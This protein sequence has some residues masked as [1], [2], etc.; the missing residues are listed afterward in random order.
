MS[1][2]P[3]GKKSVVNTI[4][5][6]RT[7]RLGWAYLEKIRASSRTPQH[8]AAGLASSYQSRPFNPPLKDSKH[9]LAHP[10]RPPHPK[11][12]LVWALL[13]MESSWPYSVP[14]KTAPC[15]ENLLRLRSFVKFRQKPVSTYTQEHSRKRNFSPWLLAPFR[16]CCERVQ[17]FNMSEKKNIP[18]GWWNQ[19]LQDS[20]HGSTEVPR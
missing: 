16:V 3:N 14:A 8:D 7:S 13:W 11:P 2:P 12:S 19:S 6:F 10:S 4:V 18:Q 5:G 17:S 20:I 1:N 15:P 9:I